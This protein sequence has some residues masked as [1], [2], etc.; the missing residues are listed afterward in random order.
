[1][2]KLILLLGL[3]RASIAP[4][5]QAIERPSIALGISPRS[6]LCP[7]GAGLKYAGNEA[8]LGIA[9]WKKPS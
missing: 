6:P 2:V 4:M 7:H 3:V 5:S 8:L 1:M 9:S